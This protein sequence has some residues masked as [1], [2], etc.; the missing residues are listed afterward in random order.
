[1]ILR[2]LLRHPR[3]PPSLRTC[4]DGVGPIQTRCIAMT[5]GSVTYNTKRVAVEALLFQQ[6]SRNRNCGSESCRPS[7]FFQAND[8]ADIHVSSEC[9]LRQ[10][11]H[12]TA[13][14]IWDTKCRR[15]PP[16]RDW[17]VV[18]PSITGAKTSDISRPKDRHESAALQSGNETPR[19]RAL[20]RG[21]PEC[22]GCRTVARRTF[23]RDAAAVDCGFHGDTEGTQ[24]QARCPYRFLAQRSNLRYRARNAGRDRDGHLLLS[25]VAIRGRLHSALDI[26]SPIQFDRQAA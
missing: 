18:A 25:V 1:M 26:T 2:Y 20:S 13:T 21:R 17:S 19:R 5:A 16:D 3:D 24:A 14:R 8:C 6:L 11:R 10:V 9:F 7:Q 15:W 12:R 22:E 4:T 23:G